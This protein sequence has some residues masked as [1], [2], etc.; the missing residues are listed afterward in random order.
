MLYLE[1]DVS[2]PD[3]APRNGF[4]YALGMIR[5]NEKLG[6]QPFFEITKLYPAKPITGTVVTPDG[7][8]AANVTI[9]G[10]T[11][12]A[13]RSRNHRPMSRVASVSLWRRRDKA[14]SGCNPPIMSL[15]HVN[16]AGRGLGTG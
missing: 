11:Y 6:G 12:P 5:K 15:G 7:K 13:E 14:A 16:L 3:Y 10:Y 8:P 4:G 9:S 1:F 2:H